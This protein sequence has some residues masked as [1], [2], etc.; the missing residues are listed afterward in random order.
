MQCVIE[1]EEASNRL[2]RGN[3]SVRATAGRS[4]VMT[5]R[6]EAPLV[7][8]PVAR[9]FEGAGSPA[10][11]F[12]SQ[13]G[14][15]WLAGDRQEL[16]LDVEEGAALVVRGQASSRA[17][18]GAGAS[19]WRLRARVGV[20]ASLAWLGEPVVPSWD[21]DWSGSAGFELERGA[22]LVVWDAFTG[23]RIAMGERFGFRRFANALE[24]RRSDGVLVLRDAVAFT[25][26]EA[27]A[28]SGPMTAFASLVIAG[29]RW[30]AE[31]DALGERVAQEPLGT[32]TRRGD[33]GF[34]R[35]AVPHPGALAELRERM[36]PAL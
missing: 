5:C 6:A 11:V 23:G 24:V 20:G 2:A 28:G 34:A 3:L 14:G 36:L 16:A 8:R 33:V 32:F 12:V 19:S 18:G 4:R 26:A 10:L 15:G 17:Y 9:R 1:R 21:S 22:S 27:A 7:L 31:L 30:E 35:F 29:P 25:G 13:L